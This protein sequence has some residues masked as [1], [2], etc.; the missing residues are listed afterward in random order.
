MFLA[1]P[2]FSA[3]EVSDEIPIFKTLVENELGLMREGK[4][5]VVCQVL[6]E[7]LDQS[8]STTTIK[9]LT[10]DENSWHPNDPKGTRSHVV[11]LDTRVRQAARKIP[12]SVILYLHPSRIDPD[13]SLFK[14]GTF[15]HELAEAADLNAG[16]FSGDY[17]IQERRE[18]FFRNAWR[19]SLGLSLIEV[20]GR[21][22]TKDYGEAKRRGLIDKK[23]AP[24]FPILNP[25][26]FDPTLQPH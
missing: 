1:C 9:P 19:E 25:D 6:I 5:G 16:L 7:R 26:S 22:S 8:S 12:T 11:A 17:Q 13:L 2:L 23:F 3:I 21:T 20:S 18:A 14:L 4:R 15:V 10:K 24:F